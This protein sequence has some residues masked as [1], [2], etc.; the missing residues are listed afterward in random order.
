MI[1]VECYFFSAYLVLSEYSVKKTTSSLSIAFDITQPWRT[2]DF[3]VYFNITIE[4]PSSMYYENVTLSDLSGVSTMLYDLVGKMLRVE[5]M[6]TWCSCNR[7]QKT[8]TK[9]VAPPYSTSC[10]YMLTHSL[11]KPAEF[12]HSYK[13]YPKYLGIWDGSSWLPMG[14]H[15]N[16]WAVAY[17]RENTMWSI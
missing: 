2:T 7:T 8:N 11:T 17:L 9:L 14:V 5:N 13:H 15:R 3:I 12:R 6:Q 1:T 10:F 16:M 4:G